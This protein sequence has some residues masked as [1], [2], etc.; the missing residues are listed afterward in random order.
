MPRRRFLLPP[1]ASAAAPQLSLCTAGEVEGRWGPGRG[2]ALPEA[3]G[4]SIC[5][6]TERG[7][8][9]PGCLPRLLAGPPPQAEPRG[10]AHRAAV[11]TLP[12]SGDTE[13]PGRAPLPP[14][15]RAA[16]SPLRTA[17]SRHGCIYIERERGLAVRRRSWIIV[18]RT[19]STSS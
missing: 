7:K 19:G 2:W 9:G 18:T 11:S 5:H 6:R 17:R 13:H 8:H 3:W 12:P 16:S 10:L 14:R 1:K 4:G 15:A